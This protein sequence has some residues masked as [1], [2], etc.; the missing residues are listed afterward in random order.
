MAIDIECVGSH[1]PDR[2]MKAHVPRRGFIEIGIPDKNLIHVSIT[3]NKERVHE[4]AGIIGHGYISAWKN[5]IDCYTMCYL[6]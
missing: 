2:N 6:G 5:T 1:Q 3:V 4:P